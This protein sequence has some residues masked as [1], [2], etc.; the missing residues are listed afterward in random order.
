M[1]LLLTYSGMTAEL[2]QMTH[3]SVNVHFMYNLI[4]PLLKHE[5]FFFFYRLKQY[6]IYCGVS[7]CP[8][9]RVAL[10]KW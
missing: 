10:V 9:L 6:N 4:I 5:D 1:I 2:S 3:M 8:S 7:M